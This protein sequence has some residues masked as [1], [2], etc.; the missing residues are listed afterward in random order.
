M[1]ELGR[2][3]IIREVSLLSSHLALSR[4]GH[5]DAM[6]HV[7]AYLK[8]KH[9]STVAFDPSYP[10]VDYDQFY[11]CDWKDFNRDMKEPVPPNAPSQE[12][13]KWTQVCLLTVTLPVI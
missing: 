11:E 4:E 1:V 12:A 8:A 3:D 10:H 2:V 5:L 13:R 9:N 6:L 7:F